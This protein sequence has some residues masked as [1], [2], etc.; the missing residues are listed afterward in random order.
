M[1]QRKGAPSAFR[2]TQRNP[3]DQVLF[4]GGNTVH[5]LADDVDFQLIG[6]FQRDAQVARKPEAESVKSRTEVGC[7]CRNA[8]P[9]LTMQ[10]KPL[11]AQ[12]A[13]SR[14]QTGAQPVRKTSE[15][16]E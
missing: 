12:I 8:E 13:S 16:P 6:R 9:F 11:V 7:T 14:F 10:H 3:I 2:R 15:F 1:K 4:V 5:I